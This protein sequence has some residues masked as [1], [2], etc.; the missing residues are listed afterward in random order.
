MSES[1]KL[2]CKYSREAT[3]DAG[4]EVIKLFL[5]VNEEY[6]NY[7]IVHSVSPARQCDTWRLSV[8]YLCDETL[9]RIR[10][11]TRAGA[12]WEMALKLQDR[13]DFV[14]GFAHGDEVCE[15][16]ELT[17]DGERRVLENISDMT[18]F[19]EL[20]FEVWSRGFDPSTPKT[21]AL[22]HYKKFI[23]TRDGVRVEQRVEW[24]GDFEL[25]RS[26]MAMLPP[27]KSETESYFSA[28]DK[29]S[30]PICAK[31]DM[32]G[33]DRA[34]YLTGNTGVTFCMKVEK[35]ISDTKGGI[36]FFVSDNGGVPYNKV[37]FVLPHK[38]RAR[39]GDVWNTVTHYSIQKS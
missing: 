24:L 35:Y 4:T 8:V 14:G 38:G 33:C 26:Y 27:L 37:Y 31:S 18:A 13:P 9:C 25:G 39:M 23:V 5:P 30:K 7:N 20:A 16:V 19:D 29:I 2:F 21:E 11:L 28:A 32:S 3:D 34:V 15:K 10:P 17:V 36:D 12:E 22:S 1:E 6:V